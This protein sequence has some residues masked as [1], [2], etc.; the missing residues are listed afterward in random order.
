MMKTETACPHCHK[1]ISTLSLARLRI[2]GERA[3][4]ILLCCCQC[5][6]VI[7]AQIDPVA[8]MAEGRD[9]IQADLKKLE[10]TLKPGPRDATA[11]KQANTPKKK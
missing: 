6:G 1:T 9:A 7:A 5:D 4:A 8:V 3:A 10:N 11:S 2:E